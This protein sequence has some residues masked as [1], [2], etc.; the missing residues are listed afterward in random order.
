MA[1]RIFTKEQSSAI[2]TRDK[3]LL[4]SAAAGSGK[5]ATLIERILRS[6]TDEKNPDDIS[7]MLIV[8]F[9]NAA[10]N[11][12]KT[13][14]TDALKKKLQEEPDNKRLE[15]Q[16]YMLPNASISTIDAFCNDILKNN[17]ERFG[18]SPRYRIADPIEADILAH[19]IWSALIDAAYSGRLADIVTPE[20]FEELS[21]CLTGVKNSAGLEEVFAFLYDKTKCAENG[22]GI[23]EDFKKI[24]DSASS[25]PTEENPFVRFAI[26]KTHEM[27]RHYKGAASEVIKRLDPTDPY[28]ESVRADIAHLG[29][30]C[31]AETYGL[32]R[33]R[34]EEDIPDLKSIR[35]DRSEEQIMYAALRKAFKDAIR[36]QLSRYYFPTEDEWQTH[37]SE[38]A[39]LVGIIAKFIGKFDTVYFEEKRR[40]SI[41]EYSD[42]ERLTYLSLYNKD[43]SLT[44]LALSLRQQY[45]SVYIDEYQDV[46]ALQNKIFLAVSRDDNRFTVGDIKQS[47]YGFRSARPDIF[48]DMKGAY[49]PLEEAEDSKCATIFMSQNFRC[50]EPI[51]DFV[52]SVFDEMFE[53]AGESIGYV[54]EDRLVFSKKYDTA[55]PEYKAPEVHLF[56][57]SAIDELSEEESGVGPAPIWVANKIKELFDSGE[58]LNSGKPIT[59]SDIAIIMRGSGK[60]P[61][62][63]EALEAKGIKVRSTDTKNF[64]LNPEVQLTLC[65]LNAIN[66][67]KRDIYLAGLMLSPLFNFSPDELYLARRSGGTSLWESAKKFSAEN[68]EDRKFASLITSLERYRKIAEGMRADELILRLYRETGILAL[69]AKNGRKDNLLLLYNYARKFESSSFEGLYNFIKYISDIIAMDTEFP[70]KKEDGSDGAVTLMTVHKSKGLEFPVVFLADASA[71]LVS[72]SEKKQ[73]VSY[74]EEYGIGMRTRRKGG[75][76]LLENPIYNIII[77]SNTEKSLEEELRVYY[78]ALTRARERLFV[79]GSIGTKAAEDYL[80]AAAARRLYKSRYSLSEAKTFVEI[81][82]LVD[83]NAKLFLK[84]G[85]SET[86][87][88]TEVEEIDTPHAQEPIA[89]NEEAKDGLIGIYGTLLERFSFVYPDIHLTA[90]P[91]KMSISKLSPRVLDGTDGEI[92]L[93]IDKAPAPEAKHGRL[94]E[95]ISGTSEHESARRGT[96]THNFLQ[97]FDLD[98]LSMLGARAELERLVKAE[99]LSREN[100]D[101]VR[102]DEIE[103][104]SRSTLF[105]EMKAAKK[106][107]REFRFSVMLPAPLFTENEEKKKALADSRI[108]LQGV[109]DCMLEDG[110][111]NIHLIDYKTDRLTEKELADKELART[112]LSEKHK[113]QLTYYAYAARE[114]FG[115]APKSVK[116]YSLPLGDTVDIDVDF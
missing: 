39:R 59:P 68:P 107:Y 20:E 110:D 33:L 18:V 89:Q 94:P 15:R 22:V 36:T 57:R 78:V 50:D 9:T 84:D 19:S 40:R 53:I 34:L 87:E 6:I 49:P 65:L 31:D 12:L 47:I 51:I 80:T 114:I 56:A 64:F 90:L 45:T 58:T 41:L 1:E 26:R 43:G 8:T 85:D 29:E 76:A 97:F 106:L 10:V 75:I 55:P 100:A 79:T 116:I 92:E 62:Y 52:N 5:T 14:V 98:N 25:K 102:M 82:G 42:I 81:L 13:R 32:I 38:T 11:E 77:D 30:I 7:R 96:A 99:F 46:N 103:K 86:E 37:M 115:K 3:T 4:V 35:G 108:L 111:G 105:S 101:R 112:A 66:N 91:E 109:M 44:D 60:M 104:F 16:L 61:L 95:F 69:A 27:A 2:E 71:K 24:L 23:L 72:Q 21:D 63:R 48:A 83:T 113:L 70:A 17:T 74:S 88:P 28:Y 67:P 54:R 93:S 73:S